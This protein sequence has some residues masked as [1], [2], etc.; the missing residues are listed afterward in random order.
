VGKAA[1]NRVPYL[2]LER[3]RAGPEPAA[4][5]PLGAAMATSGA[6]A[7]YHVEG[8]T[9]EAC[10]PDVLAP[11]YETLVVDDLAAAYAA[12]DSD[13]REIDLAWFGCP[14]ASLDEIAGG[15]RLLDGRPVR[16]ALWI[17]AA[18][19]VRERACD[20]G[21]V[22]AIEACG[23][24]VVADMCAVV[25]PMRGLGCGTLATPSAKGATYLPSHARLR[26]RY[27]TVEQCVEAA[28]SGV[29]PA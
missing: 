23:G 11:G 29:W 8:L 10:R 20:A 12:L 18:R 3:S 16:A 13:V 28:V 27:G 1:R 21:L 9:P 15:V 22:E 6:V 5:K 2:V 4:F 7:L 24:C 26:V 17:T 19:E 25:A 14:H